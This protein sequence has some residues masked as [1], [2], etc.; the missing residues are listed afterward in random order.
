MTFPNLTNES[1]RE[2]LKLIPVYS[3]SNINTNAT[4][5]F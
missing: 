5:L 2:M 3:A 1:R 4:F